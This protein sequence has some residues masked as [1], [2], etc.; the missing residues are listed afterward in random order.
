MSTPPLHQHIHALYPF[1]ARGIAKR[2]RRDAIF[3][4]LDALSPGEVMLFRIRFTVHAG[5]SA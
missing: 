4:V 1:D 2:F 3:G 5:A